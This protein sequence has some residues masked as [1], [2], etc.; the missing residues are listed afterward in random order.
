[1]EA[2]TNG[3]CDEILGIWNYVL[4]IGIAYCMRLLKII[5]VFLPS[6]RLNPLP[7]KPSKTFPFPKERWRASKSRAI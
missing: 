4:E 3:E 1:M 6:D 7:S 5:I 2:T